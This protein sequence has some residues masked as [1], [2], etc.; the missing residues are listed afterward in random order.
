MKKYSLL[1]IFTILFIYCQQNPKTKIDN[2]SPENYIRY[3]SGLSI[4]KYAD[5]SIGKFFEL[6]KKEAY[7]KNTI[8]VVIADHN[9]RTYGK[10][11]VPV[12]KFH[13]P[14]LIIAP[15]VIK[16]S[17]Y[18]N[19]ASQMDIPSTVLALSGITTNSTMPGR[20]LMKL[21]KETKGR[22]IMLFHETYAFRVG[23]DIVIINPNTKP[24]QFQVKSDTELIPAVL[25]E[26]LAKDALAHIVAS[27]NLYKNRSYKLE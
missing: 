15:N 6:A 7:F 18:D 5:F 13:I 17:T 20:N 24:L 22:T 4:Q 12:N 21:P 25:N 3:A 1:F 23:D 10:N 8:F 16:G 19:L 27:S 14:A 9:T 26:E 2:T 11:L